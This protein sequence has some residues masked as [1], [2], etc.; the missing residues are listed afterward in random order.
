MS[1]RLLGVPVSPFVRKVAAICIE[2][3]I[4]YSLEP[5]SP[6]APPDGWRKTSPLGKIPAL[7]HDGKIINDSSVI[8]AY[9][10]RVFPKPAMY[11]TDP[12]QYARVAWIEEFVDGGIVPVAGPKIVL[13][14]V[15]RPLLTRTP[16]DA[17]A[18]EA[19][20][21][22]VEEELS[23][24]Y[25][26]LEEQLGDKPFYYGDSF[27]IADLTVGSV[28][29]NLRHAG[30]PPDAKKF[31]KLSAYVYKLHERPSFAKLIAGEKPAFGARWA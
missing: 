5:V 14:L 24:L 2:K 11:P 3:Q 22:A 31:P 15:V 26:Y 17:A 19:A 30:F 12:Y 4:D 10:D 23:P 18:I 27:S 1:I 20:T 7:D 16:P 25:A 21:K 28:F 6:F 29:V 13:P 9:L 8:C